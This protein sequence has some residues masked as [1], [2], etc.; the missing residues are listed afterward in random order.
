MSTRC[1]K[2]IPLMILAGLCVSLKPVDFGRV[3]SVY[4]GDTILLHNRSRVRY[5]GINAPEID[6][7]GKGSEFKVCS[8]KTVQDRMTD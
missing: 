1:I 8:K 2:I 7:K 5:L 4:D 3:I 6:H